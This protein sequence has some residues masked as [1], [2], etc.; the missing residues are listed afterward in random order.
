[1]ASVPSVGKCGLYTAQVV[2]RAR[3]VEAFVLAEWSASYINDLPDSA[4]AYIEPGGEKDESGRTAP[5]SLRHFPHHDAG[6]DL[7]LP[8]LRNALSR[9]P[10]SDVWPKGRQHLESHATAEQ[11]G[12]RKSL[13]L[14]FTGPDTIEG[15]AFPFGYDTDQETFTKDTDLCIDWFGESGRPVLYDHGLDGQMKASVV[16][17]QNE[18]EIRAEGI[19]AQSE[20][21]RNIRYRKAI[22]ELIAAG[23]LGYSSGA[24]NHLASKN[25]KGEITRWPWVELS[26]TP[27]PAHPGSLVHYVK[28]SDAIAHLEA[29]EIEIP[30]PLKAALTA[31]DEWAQNRDDD[32]LPDG[33]KFA[34]H[35]D[36]LLAEVTAF[37]DRA[38]SISDLRAKSGRVLSA[39]TRERLMRH[40]ASL[41]ELADDLDGLLSEAD[42]TKAADLVA[43]A[44]DT[45]RHL[46]RL[47][48]VALPQG[49]PS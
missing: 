12:G 47:L 7:D 45:E 25:A 49:D 2:P 27:I 13:A 33:L 21:K 44:M 1:V 30:D 4:F 23:A 43:L 16:G 46:S 19:W 35:A 36:R 24:M 38:E 48:G 10:Q 18:Y 22:D 5:R 11:V 28:S 37:R 34:E 26:L 31:L 41:R 17:R 8:H 32:G 6:G 40:P 39:S 3:P 14:K 9:G 15:L 29:V 42:A 20:L